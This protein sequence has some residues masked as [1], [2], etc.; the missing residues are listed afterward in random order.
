MRKLSDFG[1]QFRC[2]FPRVDVLLLDQDLALSLWCSLFE[3]I[4]FDFL[5]VDY[6]QQS[7]D[8]IIAV[9]IALLVGCLKAA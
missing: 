1:L 5:F 9:V 2:I 4:N 6:I 8:F 7:P 3:H